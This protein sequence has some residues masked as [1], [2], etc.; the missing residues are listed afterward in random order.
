MKEWSK[1]ENTLNWSEVSLT[2]LH[3]NVRKLSCQHCILLKLDL[4][5]QFVK[6]YFAYIGRKMLQI[7]TE[8]MET[9]IIDNLQIRQLLKDL[10]L[11]DLF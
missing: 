11:W 5:K 1:I 2:I 9:G 10:V 4:M 8:K 7:S 6:V 3:L